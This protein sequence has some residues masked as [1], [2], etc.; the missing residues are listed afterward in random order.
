MLEANAAERPEISSL[1]AAYD[2]R[3]SLACEKREAS[4]SMEAVDC[5]MDTVVNLINSK[6][7][8]KRKKR[9]AWNYGRKLDIKTQKLR[10]SGDGERKEREK[11]YEMKRKK[12]TSIPREKRP[13]GAGR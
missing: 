3:I 1:H 11:K 13:H 5:G 10:N 7:K 4:Y 9:N 12:S 8:K 6:K 2:G